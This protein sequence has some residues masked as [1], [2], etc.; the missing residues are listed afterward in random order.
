MDSKARDVAS[1]AIDIRDVVKVFGAPPD[2]VRA[3]QS[4]TLDIRDTRPHSAS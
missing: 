2:E 3:L 1:V 4:V